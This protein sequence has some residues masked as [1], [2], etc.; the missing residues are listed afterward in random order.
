MASNDP[1]S[2]TVT[3]VE[4]TEGT[5]YLVAFGD[6]RRYPLPSSVTYYSQDFPAA[7]GENP[8]QPEMALLAPLVAQLTKP[9]T[10]GQVEEI[11]VQMV[12]IGNA[13][14][15]SVYDALRCVPERTRGL[16]AAALLI[17]ITNSNQDVK[18]AFH[19]IRHDSQLGDF[20]GALIH[21]CLIICLYRMCYRDGTVQ[22]STKTPDKA[23]TSDPD[24]YDLGAL[25]FNLSAQA[26]LT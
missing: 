6:P 20:A 10:V 3:A 15:A 18:T 26:T 12:P 7:G 25:Y 1:P 2:P 21:V 16:G 9:E 17:N 8:Y 19:W 5:S 13:I 4:H 11:V 24:D 22:A 14:C 23:L